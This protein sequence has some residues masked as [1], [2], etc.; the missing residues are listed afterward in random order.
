MSQTLALTD[1]DTVDTSTKTDPT[2][3]TQRKKLT[4]LMLTNA[5]GTD[6]KTNIDK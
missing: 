5:L 3:Q 6:K 4:D 2:E 1:G